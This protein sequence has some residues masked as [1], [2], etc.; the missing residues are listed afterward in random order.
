MPELAAA[1]CGGA[2]TSATVEELLI[3]LTCHDLEAQELVLAAQAIAAA[4][5]AADS[6]TDATRQTSFA[7]YEQLTEFV[8]EGAGLRELHASLDDLFADALPSPPATLQG[9]LGQ[10]AAY[11]AWLDPIVKARAPD[12][13]GYRLL[14]LDLGLND[15]LRV[16]VVY[17]LDVERIVE[18]AA[19]IDLHLRPLP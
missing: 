15:Q 8:V 19:R 1:D 3:L 17:R 4:R 14:E 11:A 10:L 2:E 5:E 9:D 18:L 7:F 16:L 12:R 6:P 13:G